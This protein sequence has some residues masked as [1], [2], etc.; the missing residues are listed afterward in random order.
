MK[1]DK[2]KLIEMKTAGKSN[3]ECAKVFGCITDSVR[4]MCKKLEAEGR[5]TPEGSAKAADYIEETHLQTDA[6]EPTAVPDNLIDATTAVCVSDAQT[7]AEQLAKEEAAEKACLDEDTNVLTDED[8][9]CYEP[10]EP[11]HAPIP[12]IDR[13]SFWSMRCDELRGAICEFACCGLRVDPEWVEEYNELIE[14][15]RG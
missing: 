8:E 10:V 6:V 7:V 15:C 3:A 11:L 4:R 5:L 12:P 9:I 14:R 2:E 1:I 13:K